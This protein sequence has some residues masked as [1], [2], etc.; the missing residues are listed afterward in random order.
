MRRAADTAPDPTTYPDV[1]AKA[2]RAERAEERR[3]WIEEGMRRGRRAY[4]TASDQIGEGAEWLVGQTEEFVDARPFAS[5]AAGLVAGLAI[6]FL[7]GLAIW[8]D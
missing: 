8:D 5:L 2:S 6:G 1:Q 3:A 4:E 7:V